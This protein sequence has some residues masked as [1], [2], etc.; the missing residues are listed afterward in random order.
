MQAAALRQMHRRIPEAHAP[1]HSVK[2]APPCPGQGEQLRRERRGVSRSG[3]GDYPGL[4]RSEGRKYAEGNV[5]PASLEVPLRQPHVADMVG[6][7]SGR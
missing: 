7:L 5:V 6:A 2:T 1:Y 3:R 4:S